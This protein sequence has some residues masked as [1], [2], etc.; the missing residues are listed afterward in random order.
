[1][2]KIV[3]LNN[4]DFLRLVTAYLVLFSHQFALSGQPSLNLGDQSLDKVRV[5]IFFSISGYLISQSWDRDPSVWRFLAKRILRI[6]PGLIVVTMVTALLLGP[7]IS[8]I[9]ADQY[10]LNS[11]TWEFFHILKLNIRYELPGVFAANPFP[12]AVNGSLWTL[13]IEFRWYIILLVLNV[14]GLVRCR[15]L[16]LIGAIALAIFVFAIHDPQHTAHRKYSLEFGAF[17]CY[18]VCLYYFRDFWTTRKELVLFVLGVSGV[19]L[20]SVGQKYAALFVVLP[21]LVIFFGTA[22]TPFIRRAGRFGDFSYG[23]YIYAFP[24]Q[25]TVIWFTDNR[26]SIWSGLA[27]STAITIALAILSWHWVERPALRL[28][29]H[30]IRLKK[31][32]DTSV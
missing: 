9:P 11:K 3:S 28:K 26:L 15:L 2:Q 25:Q 4:F 27:V 8:T 10:F 20:F 21:T 17:F 30:F 16:L 7:I 22:S 23:I 6:W 19:T 18:G 13:P 31:A 32:T 1:M 29:R 24:V 5:L 12:N 14:V